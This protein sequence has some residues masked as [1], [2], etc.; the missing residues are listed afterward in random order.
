MNRSRRHG[1]EVRLGLSVNDVVLSRAPDPH[2]YIAAFQFKL[3]DV[4]FD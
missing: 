3:G 4:L 1:K 2:L